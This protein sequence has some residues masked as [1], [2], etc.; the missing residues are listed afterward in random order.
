MSTQYSMVV[1]SRDTA[2]ADTQ[3]DLIAENGYWMLAGLK[4]KDYFKAITS[5]I[6]PAAV[7]TRTNMVYASG[8]ITFSSIA[9][10]DT[11]TVSSI[12]FTAKTS[13]ATGPL[14]FNIGASDTAAAA[15][16]VV[17]INAQ[18]VT[19]LQVV[20]SSALG[21]VTITAYLPGAMGNAIPIAISAHGSVSGSGILT[22]GTNGDQERTHYYGSA[23]STF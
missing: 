12:V 4:L 5:G 23:G 16:A 3:R 14:Q 10:A 19:S 18:A 1:V 11:V 9:D 15:N 8:T 17:A 21:V 22:S 7:Q 13:G 2:T 20:A 6:H